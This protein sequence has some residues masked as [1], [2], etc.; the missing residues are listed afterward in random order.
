LDDLNREAGKKAMLGG[1]PGAPGPKNL[2]P[3][4]EE[5]GAG[6]QATAAKWEAQGG[7]SGAALR[8]LGVG[9]NIQEDQLK[10]QQKQTKQLEKLNEK[11]AQGRLVFD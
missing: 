10:E 11:A 4:L 8:G 2:P 3:G 7:F 9:K 5:M 1:L 6:V